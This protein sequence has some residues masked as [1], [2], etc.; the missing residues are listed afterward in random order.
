MEMRL[1]HPLIPMRYVH[2]ALPALFLLAPMPRAADPGS[3]VFIH[4]DGAGLGHWN[5]GRLLAAGPD[6]TLNWDRMER[7]A[8]YRVHQKDWLGTSSHAGGTVHAYG[9]KWP[10][11]PTAWTGTAR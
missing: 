8:A 2:L 7:L 6:G 1:P 4:P 11:T 10:P 5:A 9:Q 3:V